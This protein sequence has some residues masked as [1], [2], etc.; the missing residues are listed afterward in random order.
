MKQRLNRK[1]ININALSEYF[2]EG[3]TRDLHLFLVNYSNL[4]TDK[5]NKALDAIY[6][7]LTEKTEE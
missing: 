2:C 7:V 3:V 1:G 6:Q 4:T 5:I